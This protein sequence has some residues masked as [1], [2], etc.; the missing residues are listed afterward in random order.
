MKTVA[1]TVG[2]PEIQLAEYQPEYETVTAARIVFSDR[3]IGMMT[4]WEL[5]DEERERIAAGDDVYL[6][7]YT[8][9]RPMQPVNV[10]IGH[11]NWATEGPDLPKE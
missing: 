10:E 6:T 7:V 2:C 11:P 9:G 4:R 5:D 1:P 8:H 3:S